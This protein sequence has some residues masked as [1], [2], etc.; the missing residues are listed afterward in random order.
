[1][2][3]DAPLDEKGNSQAHQTGKCTVQP[4]PLSF[5]ASAPSGTKLALAN[6]YCYLIGSGAHLCSPPPHENCKISGVPAAWLPFWLIRLPVPIFWLSILFEAPWLAKIWNHGTPRDWYTNWLI[7]MSAPEAAG[8][9]WILSHCGIIK[10]LYPGLWRLDALFYSVWSTITHFSNWSLEM[11]IKEVLHTNNVWSDKYFAISV[12]VIMVLLTIHHWG[13]VI[14]LH[15][16]PRKPGP[17]LRRVMQYR[18]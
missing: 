3:R 2:G 16:G 1:M 15:Y 4:Y 12:G 11:S 6:L 5:G 18:R 17:I 14:Y 7:T 10:C 8:R 13:N 9:S